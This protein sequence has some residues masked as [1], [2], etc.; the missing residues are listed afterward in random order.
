MKVRIFRG[1]EI[2]TESTL[3]E[4]EDVIGSGD[5]AHLCIANLGGW[6]AVFR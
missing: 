4:G 6:V 2:L 3:G 1:D 5:S